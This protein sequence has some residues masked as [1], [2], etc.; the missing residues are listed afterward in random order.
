MRLSVKLIKNYANINNFDFA[1]EWTVREGDQNNLYFQIVN[2]DQDSL[3]YLPTNVSY[4]LQVTFPAVN[5]D[6]VIVK[7]AVQAD[8]LDRSVWYVTLN[9]TDLPSSGNVQFA[10]TEGT[11]IRRWGALSA[12]QVEKL[13]DG[14][15]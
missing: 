7:T 14:G 15:C 3:R 10:L 13:N 4:S 6:N 2:L 5:G 9:S 11:A 12:L 1:S 8:S